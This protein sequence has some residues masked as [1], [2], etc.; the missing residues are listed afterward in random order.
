M[1]SHLE[2]LVKTGKLKQFLYQP[3]RQGNQVGL[4]AQRDAS[5]RPPLGTISIILVAPGITGSHPSKV[6]SIAWPLAKDSSPEPKRCRIEVR[7]AL[8]FSD[9]DKVRTLQPHDD[10][11]LV[12][13]KI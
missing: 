5:S 7:L 3:N 12:T 13:L 11:L 2:K 6:M 8:S 9:E 10:A 4:G 1:W